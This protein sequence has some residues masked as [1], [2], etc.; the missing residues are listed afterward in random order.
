[1]RQTFRSFHYW[2]QAPRSDCSHGWQIPWLAN[3]GK[4][5]MSPHA[6]GRKGTHRTNIIYIVPKREGWGGGD[7]PETMLKNR[8]VLSSNMRDPHVCGQQKTADCT[9][10][11]MLTQCMHWCRRTNEHNKMQ[12]STD[13]CLMNLS[14]SASPNTT[15]HKGML[16]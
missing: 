14:A 15:G 16:T 12:G 8:V 1:M 4:P 11:P 3:P 9:G 2:Q 5:A 6:E 13:P 10:L 7:N